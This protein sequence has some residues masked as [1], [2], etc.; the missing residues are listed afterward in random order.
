MHF[1]C[2]NRDLMWKIRGLAWKLKN[3]G[4]LCCFANRFHAWELGWAALVQKNGKKAIGR[5]DNGDSIQF[6]LNTVLL[7]T[8]TLFSNNGCVQ[9]QA[10]WDTWQ[11]S[12][13]CKQLPLSCLCLPWLYP[14]YILAGTNL[15]S[16]VNTLFVS[17]LVLTPF[18][19]PCQSCSGVARGGRA[20]PG[21]SK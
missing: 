3:M 4:H 7:A 17:P 12:D 8:S 14:C 18:W 11:K 21:V 2:K 16:A 5:A 6:L 19:K 9:V 15:G 13:A 10:C 20:L 1:T